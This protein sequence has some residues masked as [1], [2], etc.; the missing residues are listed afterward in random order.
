MIEKIRVS[1]WDIFSFFLTGMLVVAVF[2]ALGTTFDWMRTDAL[3]AKLL[4]LPVSLLVIGGSLFFTMLG[5]LLEP[6][7]NYSD[8][9]MVGPVYSLFF[10][11]KKK[12][13]Q[14]QEILERH[15]SENYMGSLNGVIRNPYG[16]CK[17]YVET[18][19]LSTTFM[20][21]LSRYGFYRNCSFIALVVA[22]VLFFNLSNWCG[23]FFGCAFACFFVLLFKRR[24]EDFYSLMAPAVY[25]AFLI[26]KNPW[27]KSK[28]SGVV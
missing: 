14:E 20:V 28:G 9:F 2:I 8:T 11:K 1:L 6:L 26:D 3:I 16:I 17:E 12:H 27:V 7:A 21:Y 5:M 24:S 15:I 23:K 4:V 18:K 10:S 22:I 13:I 25:R 19:Q